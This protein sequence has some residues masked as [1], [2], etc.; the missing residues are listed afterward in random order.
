[1]SLATASRASATGL[2]RRLVDRLFELIEQVDERLLLS[3]MADRDRVKIDPFEPIEKHDR[4]AFPQVEH[5]VLDVVRAAHVFPCA[6]T[7][8]GS[9][10]RASACIEAYGAAQLLAAVIRRS[11]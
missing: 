4:V 3:S 6:S 2:W 10:G 11:G 8:K 7:A 9:Y 1:M 5:H